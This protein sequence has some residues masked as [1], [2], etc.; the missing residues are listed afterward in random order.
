MLEAL[1]LRKRAQRTSKAAS[2]S[3]K[4]TRKKEELE[5]IAKSIRQR[6]HDVPA[7]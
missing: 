6:L 5:F 1:P 3:G 4:P 7:I 2:N